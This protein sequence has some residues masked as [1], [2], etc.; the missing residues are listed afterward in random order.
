MLTTGTIA[1]KLGVTRAKVSY[2]IE[3]GKIEPFMRAGIARLFA[4]DQLPAIEAAL[5][6]IGTQKRRT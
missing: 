3:K 2:A 5:E 6:S 4:V 1:K